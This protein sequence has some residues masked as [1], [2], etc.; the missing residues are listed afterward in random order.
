MK[1]LFCEHNSI[2][3]PGIIR[4][5]RAMGHEIVFSINFVPVIST[6]CHIC[7]ISYLCWIVDSPVIQLYSDTLFLHN[8][9]V[10]IFDRTLYKE[11]YGRNP[12]HIFY[13]PLGCDFEWY[14][15]IAA[16][17]EEYDDYA[18]DVSFVGSLYSEKCEYNGIEQ[19]LPE[20]LQGYFRGIMAAQQKIYGYNFLE[21]MLSGE[22]EQVLAQYVHIQQ[23]DGYQMGIKAMW[24]KYF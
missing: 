7:N 3:E 18:C 23:C 20:Y 22:I 5:F 24:G 11:F 6:A 2:C 8:N 1:I 13:L 10:F 16:T 17:P 21:E 12:G 15:K 4:A 14:D 9:Y 19:R